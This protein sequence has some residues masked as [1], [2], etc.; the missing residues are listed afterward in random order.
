[1]QYN[2]KIYLSKKQNK[3]SSNIT[4]K[5]IPHILSRVIPMTSKASLTTKISQYLNSKAISNSS[6]HKDKSNSMKRN[7][8]SNDNFFGKLSQSTVDVTRHLHQ[9]HRRLFSED[10]NRNS[11]KNN[12]KNAFRFSAITS[13]KFRDVFGVHEMRNSNTLEV[14]IDKLNKNSN[15]R[16]S[17][18]TKILH[19]ISKQLPKEDEVESYMRKRNSKHSSNEGE[20]V[21][22]KTASTSKKEN[23]IGK[24]Q[25]YKT[26]KKKLKNKND[27]LEK[28]VAMK[29]SKI[30]NVKKLRQCKSCDLMKCFGSEN[31][32]NTNYDTKPQLLV[33]NQPCQKVVSDNNSN[34]NEKE[35]MK[36]RAHRTKNV[37]NDCNTIN[38]SKNDMKSQNT[39]HLETCSIFGH[40][41]EKET[42]DEGHTASKYL[43]S[44]I[45]SFSDLQ[46]G[47]SPGN[48]NGTSFD[49]ENHDINFFKKQTIS[50]NQRSSNAN[51]TKSNV[52]LSHLKRNENITY[53]R[54][55]SIEKTEDSLITNEKKAIGCNFF[56]CAFS[57]AH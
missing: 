28:V 10:R 4:H 35:I 55:I 36:V 51:S 33:S 24:K 50:S 47:L 39:S 16:L 56:G 6:K 18:Y 1:M 26:K 44:K 13:K 11:S 45:T 37:N 15:E 5:Q 19:S 52:L 32:Y 22:D 57:N 30:Q 8:I 31:T 7:E 20:I 38:N 2:I 43:F 49:P 41:D 48:S 3:M 27:L 14:F 46:K 17:L 9:T 23:T 12:N 42:N 40:I 34:N 21:L 53:K 29:S 25:N 54:T